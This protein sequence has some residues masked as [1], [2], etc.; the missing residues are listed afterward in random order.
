LAET[1]GEKRMGGLLG[2]AMNGARA[3]TEYEVDNTSEKNV[4]VEV[5][6]RRLRG[7]R[8]EEDREE[9]GVKDCGAV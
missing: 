2:M 7:M 5:R 6:E 9:G 4:N 8:G 3:G 1:E